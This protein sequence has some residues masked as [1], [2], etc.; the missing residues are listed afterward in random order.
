MNEMGVALSTRAPEGGDRTIAHGVS[1]GNGCKGMPALGEGDRVGVPTV[2]AALALAFLCIAPAGRAAST[3]VAF[4]SYSLQTVMVPMRDGVK[5]ATDIYLPAR[6]GKPADGKFPVLIERT[7]YGGAGRKKAGDLLAR[8]GYVAIVQN[9]RGRFGSEGQFAPFEEGT[10]GYDAIEWAA[11]QP[12]SNGK[13]GSFG[14]SYTGMDQYNAAM[15][16][17]PHLIGMFVQMAGASLYDSVSYP[18]GTPNSAW[19]GWILR[20][21]ETSPQ[22]ERK[23][24]AA[25]AI[26]SVV[27]GNFA[28]WLKQPP[29]SRAD[30]LAEF[31][32]YL[33]LYRQ[34]YSHS[35][36]DDFWKQ[37]R[38]Y[39]AGYYG[40]LKDVPTLFVTGWYDNFMQGTL[41]VF[42]TVS[43][44]QKTEKK[45]IVG[46]W[47]HGIGTPMC[48]AAAFTPDT[49][50][51]QPAL[52]ADWFDH[53]LHQ[54]PFELIS[55]QKVQFYR[56]GAGDGSRAARGKLNLGGEWR[57][58]SAWPPP[59][60][61]A[62]RY[63][64]R[65]EG[66]LA[67][68]PPSADAPSRFDFDPR[69]PVP[70]I[71][72]RFQVSG[73]PACIQDQ[74]NRRPDVLSFSSAPLASPVDLTGRIFALLWIASDAPDTDFTAK[75][76]E[77]LSHRRGAQ[78]CR[79]RDT[80]ALSQELREARDDDA[81]LGLPGDH[82]SGL[83]QRAVRRRPPHSR[84]HLQQQLPEI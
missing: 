30:L 32:D 67:A 10:D 68:D 57:T 12:W 20:S 65:A 2:T 27:R 74:V 56:M 66:A 83:R 71:G 6:G 35:S 23:K 17:P 8:R 75:L 24:A 36:L 15:Y 55:S 16:R 84:G 41:D 63:Y 62:F 42:M 39:T 1:R 69:N 81:R 25:E 33:E 13:V 47:P 4:D 43:A 14:G 44:A 5:L 9:S 82:R 51:D 21:A 48:G 31:P 18:G 11:A 26:S 22:A 76:I 64:L 45:L 37:R 53:L 38:F 60:V 79:W 54:L 3:R 19:I 80:G 58:S 40:E 50:E 78:R 70:T 59:D 52:V 61:R 46:P 49:T 29:Q 34:S 72:G 7:P 73:V 77:R 28:A